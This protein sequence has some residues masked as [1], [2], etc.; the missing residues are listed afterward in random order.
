M[1]E[2]NETKLR[3]EK[4]KRSGKVRIRRSEKGLELLQISN[5]TIEPGVGGS[6]RSCQVAH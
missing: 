1:R 6:V 4:A 2:R 5:S 3:G